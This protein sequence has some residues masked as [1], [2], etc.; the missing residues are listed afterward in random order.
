MSKPFPRHSRSALSLAV[1]AAIAM[2]NNAAAQQAT[3]DDGLVEV[4]ITG[5]RAAIETAIAAKKE[6]ESIAEVV[7]A[8]DIGKLPDTSI[9]RTLTGCRRAANRWTRAA[10]L[11]PWLR[12]R[13]YDRFA[14]RTSA[15]FSGRQPRR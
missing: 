3:S 8:E 15:G 13:L 5:I 12:S 14:E 1:A 10:N 7:S 6:S 11:D 2:S 9:H 4:T